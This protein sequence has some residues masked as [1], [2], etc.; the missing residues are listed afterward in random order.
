[1]PLAPWVRW[2]FQGCWL[3][4]EF[5]NLLNFPL[6]TAEGACLCKYVYSVTLLWWMTISQ[7]SSNFSLIKGRLA[8]TGTCISDNRGKFFWKSLQKKSPDM[9]KN[10]SIQDSYIHFWVKVILEANWMPVIVFAYMIIYQLRL[11][12]DQ[13][14][15]TCHL[16]VSWDKGHRCF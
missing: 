6:F 13:H 16:F 12:T 5:F 1:M 15:W 2:I 11:V 10:I 4:D 9:L 14:V 8:S 3:Q 7:V